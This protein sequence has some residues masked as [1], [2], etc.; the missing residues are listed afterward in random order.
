MKSMRI[1][2]ILLFLKLIA[3]PTHSQSFQ[4]PS[5]GYPHEGTWLQWPHH[6]EYGFLYRDG[7]DPTWIAMTSALITGEKVHIIAYNAAEQL[8]IT[9]LLTDASVVL[10][11]IDFYIYPTNDV[12]VRD[13]GPIFVFDDNMVLHAED[14]GFNGWGGDYNFDLDNPIPALVGTSINVPVVD[15]NSTMITEGG[16]LELDGNGVLMATKSSILTQVNSFGAQAIRN[17]GMSQ[18]EAENILQQYLGV[19]KFIWLDGSLSIY[20]VTDGHIDGFAKFANDN[21]LVTMNTNDL[22]YWGLSA[23]DADALLSASNADNVPYNIVSLPLTQNNVVTTYGNNL[24]YKGSYVNYYI[25]NDVVLVPIYNDPNDDEAIALIGQV[26]PDKT[27]VGI[28]CRNLYE[29][30]GM[31]HC[32]TQQQPF[33]SGTAAI[34][35]TT[36]GKM[37]F[38]Q[39]DPNPFI[40]STNV[41]LTLESPSLVT[42]QVF[43]ATGIEVIPP[44]QNY[45]PEG[46][47]TLTIRA[48]QLSP[49]IYMYV[50][51]LED[52]QYFGRMMVAE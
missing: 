25:A 28:D 31:V 34:N 52:K 2:S 26:H 40:N 19:I 15:L 10:D 21:T 45:L 46:L 16:A 50:I 33:V 6:Y 20:D 37:L 35:E 32:V 29:S 38:V 41:H 11:S 49:G 13:N 18:L 24:G 12:W 51:T 14:W 23:N 36:H 22:Y 1:L 48:P 30:G 4:M 7:L 47:Q 27:V 5:E 17:P 44:L 39:N 8:R 43:D 9:N 42:T 3:F